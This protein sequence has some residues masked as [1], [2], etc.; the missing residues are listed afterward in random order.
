MGEKGSR[1]GEIQSCR[2]GSRSGSCIDL[3]GPCSCRLAEAAG[4][5]L[6]YHHAS[7]LPGNAPPSAVLGGWK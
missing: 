1:A 6:A 4:S 2:W 7:E 3:A 5:L